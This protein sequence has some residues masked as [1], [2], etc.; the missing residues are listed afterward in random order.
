[1]KFR[2]S[3]VSYFFPSNFDFMMFKVAL[4]LNYTIGQDGGDQLGRVSLWFM[5]RFVFKM[6]K[7]TQKGN[8]WAYSQVVPHTQWKSFG[9]WHIH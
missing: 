9:Q 1:M 2:K 6:A 3:R 5:S 4:I 8:S 7:F